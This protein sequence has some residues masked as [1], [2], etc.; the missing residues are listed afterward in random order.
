M[1]SQTLVLV[2]IMVAAG[3]LGGWMNYLMVARDD[4]ESR[5]LLK[6]LVLVTG[7]ALMVPL[8]LNMISS[9]LME[10]ARGSSTGKGD[11]LK[12][13]V[14]VGICLVAAVFSSRFI[15]TI[16]DR[17]LQEVKEAKRRTAKV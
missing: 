10:L 6:S 9:N 1:D 4:R 7:A 8:L 5:S 14:L 15:Q 3:A 13:L 17:V 16:G 12:L 11:P 2:G